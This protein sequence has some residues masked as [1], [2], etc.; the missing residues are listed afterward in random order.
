MVAVRA[1]VPLALRTLRTHR[2]Q[3]AVTALLVALAAALLNLAALL[4]V[5][6]SANLDRSA[7]RLSASH[8]LLV[9]P[10]ERAAAE[11]HRT[12]E[13]DARVTEAE[14]RP[15]A[16]A[17]LSMDFNGTELATLAFFADVTEDNALNR[18][19]MVEE[20]GTAAGRPIW[21]PVQIRDAA[22][23]ALGDDLTLTVEG[24]DH[25]FTLQGFF[26][27]P[28]LGSQ[29]M[30][31]YE[32]RF[33]DA[34][35]AQLADAPGVFP[36]WL[37][38]SRVADRHDATDVGTSVATAVQAWTTANGEPDGLIYSLDWDTFVGGS[39][40][41]ATLFTVLLTVVSALLAAIISAIV[42]FVVRTS[43]ARDLPAIGTMK[44]TGFTSRQVVGALTAPFLAVAVG[45]GAV[46]AA[47]TLAVLPIMDHM[48]TSQNGLRWAPRYVAPT[49]VLAVVVFAAVVLGTAALASRQVRRLAAIDALRGGIATHSFRP[50]RFPLDR[51]RGSLPWLLGAKTATRHPGQN[52]LV[53]FV[54]AL[55]TYA[56]VFAVGLNA[57]VLGNPDG[58][59]QVIAGEFGDAALRLSETATPNTVR[60]AVE[61]DPDVDRTIFFENQMAYNGGMPVM[62]HVADD[63]S[64]R[65]DSSLVEGRSPSRADET[66]LGGRLAENRGLTIGDTITLEMGGGSAEYLITGITQSAAYIGVNA[67]LT[68]DGYRLLDPMFEPRALE[69]YLHDGVDTETWARD[70]AATLPDDVV[71]T[72]NL[73]DY[74]D[75][76]MSVYISMTGM[77]ARVFLVLTAAIVLLTV[78]LAVSSFLVSARR[79]YGVQKALG[80]TNRQLTIQTVAAYLPAIAAGVVVGTA[81]A[82]VSLSGTISAMLH[83][84]GIMRFDATVPWP[85]V[86]AVALGVMA[87]AAALMMLLARRTRGITAKDLLT[88]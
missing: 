74:F 68:H 28:I 49:S 30:G 20:A 8:T 42:W 52:A 86:G 23:Y 14:S 31:M 11:A 69:V 88:E 62:V 22:G 41:T 6:Y 75:S 73:R 29:N 40:I 46:G 24:V 12:L 3:L 61:A 72:L 81:V 27:S 18:P 85:Q 15:L 58:F 48:L 79:T 44:A 53:A 54:V 77:L 84:T 82:A 5:D 65:D 60:A 9:T 50:N 78:G 70:T 33:R 59:T 13:D 38:A 10:S 66:A 64:L 51:T 76:I 47:A 87:M 45:A 37:V 55:A 26:E 39:M 36:G 83:A 17:N 19:G 63:Y 2:G 80:Y 32:F 56:A 34:D 21:A 1:L 7:E 16:M 25:T 67:Q 57:N 35:L 71:D 43:I 4:V